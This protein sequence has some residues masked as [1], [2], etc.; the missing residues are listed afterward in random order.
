MLILESEICFDEQSDN[1]DG[2]PHDINTKNILRPDINF[3]NNQLFSSTIIAGKNIDIIK[4]V[5]TIRCLL[6]CLQ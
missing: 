5:N 6:K 4:K 2:L 3:G 1:L